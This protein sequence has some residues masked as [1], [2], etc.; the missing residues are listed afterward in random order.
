MV[1][2]TILSYEVLLE[3]IS[4]VWFSRSP[5]FFNIETSN[6]KK[7]T[8]E[9]PWKPILQ[10]SFRPSSHP[11]STLQFLSNTASRMEVR[12]QLRWPLK[13]LP[14]FPGRS[15][16]RIAHLGQKFDAITTPKIQSKTFEIITVWGVLCRHLRLFLISIS[17]FWFFFCF[18]QLFFKS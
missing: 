10:T 6:Q 11:F 1:C 8:A 4:T 14:T 9:N 5:L 17:F 3:P 7:S 16:D 18:F 2:M 15:P 12:I 13:A